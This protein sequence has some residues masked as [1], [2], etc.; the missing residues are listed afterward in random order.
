MVEV[1][2]VVASTGLFLVLST[3]FLLVLDVF[4]L[5]LLI[6]EGMIVWSLFILIYLGTSWSE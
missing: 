1:V 5:L 4:V 6:R 3:I 2:L